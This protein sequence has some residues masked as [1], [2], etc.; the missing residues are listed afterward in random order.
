MKNYFKTFK[1]NHK[2]IFHKSLFLFDLY[3]KIK[4]NLFGVRIENRGYGRIKKLIRGMNNEIVIGKG[5]SLDNVF[6]RIIG[7]NNRI[8]FGENCRVRN[9]C[10]FWMEGSNIE[11][12]IGNNCTFNH[13]NHFCA[14][15]DN[16]K[17]ILGDNCMFSNN[18][19]IRT[20]DSHSVLDKNTGKR[21]N[22]S[23]NVI[24]GKHVW[25]AAQVLILKGVEIGEDSIIATKALVSRSIPSNCIAAGIPAKV[26]K[27]DVTWSA[28]FE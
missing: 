20:S 17:I 22:P 9:E 5:T 28:T 23:G 2:C 8:T 4:Y 3:Y 15:E 1:R 27:T 6:F 19:T 11:I 7:N 16:T 13:T 26:I 10:S 25:V 24:I 12:I 14:Q 18:I 21:I